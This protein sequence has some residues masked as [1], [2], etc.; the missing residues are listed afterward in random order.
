MLHEMDPGEKCPD[1]VRMIVEI[2]KDSRNKY[3]FDVKLGVFR[4]DRT[5]YSPMHYPGDYGFVPGTVAADGDPIDVLVLSGE[6][7]FTGCLREVRPSGML[8]MTEEKGPDEKILAVPERNPRYE[9]VY[10][11]DQIYPHTRLE[12]EH[13]FDIY[14]ELEGKRTETKG[15]RGPMETRHAIMASRKRFLELKAAERREGA[16]G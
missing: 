9:Q 12:I 13:F 11:I 2:P 6:P 4:L 5:L 1:I 14:K 10:T 8:E 7:T 15:W 16:E 3:E